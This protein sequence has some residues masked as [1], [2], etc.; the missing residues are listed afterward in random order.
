MRKRVLLTA[1][2]LSFLVAACATDQKPMHV[3]V[4]KPFVVTLP[5]NQST[6]YQWQ[7]AKPLDEACLKL[8]GT[9]YKVS[10]ANKPGAA[11]NEQWKFQPVAEGKTE[12][13]FKYVRPWEK[14]VAP[15]RLTNFVVQVVK[16]L[17]V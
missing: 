13:Q 1:S 5:S 6:G 14:D 10:V 2:L 17:G 12:I 16:K 7:L 3:G 11:G 9:E 4:G 8:V 15:A